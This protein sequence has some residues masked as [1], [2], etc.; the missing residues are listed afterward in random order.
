MKT[1]TVLLLTGVFALM[2][3]P[4]LVNAQCAMCSAANESAMGEGGGI[5]LNEGIVYLMGIPYLLLA[6]L[7]GVFFRKQIR[8][9]IQDVKEIH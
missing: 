2:L 3:L 5:G 1:K 4:E 9:F 8:G 6:I 7:G